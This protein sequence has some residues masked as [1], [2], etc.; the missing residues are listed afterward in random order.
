MAGH[1]RILLAVRNGALVLLATLAGVYLAKMLFPFLLGIV[2]A[3]VLDPLVTSAARHRVPR[4]LGALVLLVALTGGT[5]ALL[6]V[7]LARLGAELA[8]L[9][10]SGWGEDLLR[11]LGVS[12]SELQTLLRGEPARQGLGALAGWTASLVRV[13]PGAAVAVAI[14]LLSAYLM[15]RDKERLLSAARHILPRS[16]RDEG[17]EAG[18]KVARG[19]SGVIRAQF[20]L[21]LSTTVLAIGGLS[22]VGVRYAWLLGLGAGL[23]DLVP[24][25]G[26]SGVF[27]PTAL[28]LAF[29]GIPGKALGVLA[30]A[31]ASMVIRQV[32]EPRLLAAGTG[33]HPLVMLVAVYSG[34]R[35]FGAF[36]LI[37]GPMAAAFFAAL[38]QAAVEPFLNG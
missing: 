8:S 7:G 30:V 32:L 2:I 16:I 19:F 35:L 23:L 10:E 24:M 17:A 5:A 4:S 33:L 1:D 34:Y 13:V 6:A 37:V 25:I 12:W 14:S 38:F 22:L 15:L 27:L 21:S 20:L 29:S 31:G 3:V 28:Y 9:V 11:R 18:R 36:G 26:P